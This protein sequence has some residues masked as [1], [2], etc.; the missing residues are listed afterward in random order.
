MIVEAYKGFKSDMTC[1]GFQYELGKTYKMC[2]HPIMCER[3]FH[4]CI[5][6]SRVFAYY[7]PLTPQPQNVYAKVYLEDPEIVWC[8]LYSTKICANNIRIG[9][10]LLTVKEIYKETLKFNRCAS[11]M[12]IPFHQIYEYTT[13]HPHFDLKELYERVMAA[14]EE[15][16]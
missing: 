14:K 6:P 13:A 9:E 4:A 12:G 3:G 16:V 15:N 8:D 10:K 2:G 5:V 11:A 7:P 1:R